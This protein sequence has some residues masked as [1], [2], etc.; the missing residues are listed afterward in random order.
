[1]SP[2]IQH[3]IAAGVQNDTAESWLPFLQGTCKAYEINSPNRIAG[4]LSQIAHESAGLTRLTENLNYTAERLMAVWPRRFPS[5]EFAKQ[6]GRN[7]EK[8]ANLV[9]ASR[10]GNG[11]EASGEGW[12]YRGRGLKQLTG[13]SNYAACS[14]ALGEDF[15]NDPDRLLMPVNAALSA[16]WFWS[17]NGLNRFADA[18]DFVGMTKRINGGT[19]GLEDRQARYKRILASM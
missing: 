14:K 13:K 3:V 1:M 7:P 10:M 11:D 8:I 9:Y 4:F 19:I 18:D 6:Y 2:L 17:E 5:I 16:G 15:V 12:K